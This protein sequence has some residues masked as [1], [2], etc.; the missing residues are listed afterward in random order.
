MMQP[1]I[2]V[3]PF[4]PV[5]FDW[6]DI[7]DNSVDHATHLRPT[8]SSSPQSTSSDITIDNNLAEFSLQAEQSPTVFNEF[9]GAIPTP[10]ATARDSHTVALSPF[11]SPPNQALY[12]RR[13]GRPSKA[14]LS[15]ECSGKRLYS[16]TVR[17][18]I[19]N[20]SA[21]RSRAR[22]NKSFDALW[23]EVPEKK[24]R[25]QVREKDTVRQLSRAEKVEIILSYIQ[26]L[27]TKV[28]GR[29]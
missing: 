21:M 18:E 12:H 23:K 13:P 25:I 26:D 8:L 11:D 14:Q 17:R 27:K 19:H 28:Y 1:D 15:V 20:D 2:L 16:H 29:S 24:K 3:P 9:D 7:F 22:L 6:G 4:K 10:P 5:E